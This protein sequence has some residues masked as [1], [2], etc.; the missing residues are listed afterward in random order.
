MCS[1]TVRAELVVT[2][3]AELVEAFPFSFH[4]PKQKEREGFDKLSPNG[5]LEALT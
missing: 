1:R 3:R 2:V 5:L 4:Y